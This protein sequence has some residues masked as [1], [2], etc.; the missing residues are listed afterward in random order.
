MEQLFIKDFERFTKELIENKVQ[1]L[2]GVQGNNQNLRAVFSIGGYRIPNIST[3][4]TPEFDRIENKYIII[5]P[6]SGYSEWNLVSPIGTYDGEVGKIFE[7]AV[8]FEYDA[9]DNTYENIGLEKLNYLHNKLLKLKDR[10]NVYLDIHF[11]IT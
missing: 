8:Q 4:K 7:D 9:K 10:L 1:S 5:I 11:P 2:P 3:E 6:I